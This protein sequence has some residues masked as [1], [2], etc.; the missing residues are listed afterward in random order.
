M[1]PRLVVMAAAFLA[2]SPA[3]GGAAGEGGGDGGHLPGTWLNWIYGIEIGGRPLFSGPAWVAFGWALVAALALALVSALATRRLAVRAGP[4][5]LLLET[6][7]GGMKGLLETVLGRRASEFLPFVGA[8]FIYVATMN[9][10]GLVPGSLSPTSNLSITAGLALVSFV[11]IHATGFRESRLGYVKHFVEGVPLRFSLKATA[12][13]SLLALLPVAAVVM[14][15]H[16]VNAVFLPVTLAMRLYGNIM[17]EERVIE[18]LVGLVA[19]TRQGWIPLQLPNMVL[20]VVTSLVQA[21]IFSMLTAVN[22][23]LVLRHED[24]E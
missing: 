22:L 2:T 14:V 19:H 21:V 6:V 11:A 8:I 3:A 12:I 9:L 24:Q 17:G 16:L 20:G 18:S 1:R 10:I 4:G 13:L 23:S 7:V 5:Q 15:S